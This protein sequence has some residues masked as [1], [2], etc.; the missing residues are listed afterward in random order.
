MLLLGLLTGAGVTCFD[1]DLMP[2]WAQPCLGDGYSASLPQ[3]VMSPLDGR[4][5]WLRCQ[6][7]MIS[8]LIE[9]FLEGQSPGFP[10]SWP[11]RAI[12]NVFGL[13]SAHTSIHLCLHVLIVLSGSPLDF[14]YCLSK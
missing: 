4:L 11:H 8:A 2:S 6:P 3:L 13:G 1:V 9:A 5:P 14:W 7:L 10:V 12:T